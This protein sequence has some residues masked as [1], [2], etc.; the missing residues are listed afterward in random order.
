MVIN[1]LPAEDD[2]E[3]KRHV[4]GVRTQGAEPSKGNIVSKQSKK[5]L[6][7]PLILSDFL[8]AQR[9]FIFNL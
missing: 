2:K 4:N 5:N 3:L 7:K 9:G 1:P 6:Y 8:K